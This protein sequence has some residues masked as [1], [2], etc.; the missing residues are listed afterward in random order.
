MVLRVHLAVVAVGGEV[1]AGG[2]GGRGAVAQPPEVLHASGGAAGGGHRHDPALELAFCPRLQ[3]ELPIPRLD[4]FL[5]ERDWP[6]YL[7]CKE[8]ENLI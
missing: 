1:V 7:Q 6:G 8:W 2:R 3:R 5:L 4:G